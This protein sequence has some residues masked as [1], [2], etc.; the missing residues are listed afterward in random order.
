MNFEDP[1]DAKATA[2]SYGANLARLVAV[3][4]KYDPGN[5]FRSRRGLVG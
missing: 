2:A 4:Q 3:K 5:L 1:D